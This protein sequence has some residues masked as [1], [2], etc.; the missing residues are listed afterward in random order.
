MLGDHIGLARLLLPEETLLRERL[1]APPIA[2]HGRR[3]ACRER[4]AL[5]L[6][7]E[8]VL[9][10]R[11]QLDLDTAFA[12]PHV[13]AIERKTGR[14]HPDDRRRRFHAERDARLAHEFIGGGIDLETHL[15]GA[16]RR[17]IAQ[18]IARWPGRL[19]GEGE[20]RGEEER[21]RY[22]PIM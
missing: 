7:A 5:H 20:R 21:R 22:F 15:V 18:P 1:D 4:L 11:D 8:I 17:R 19:V 12:L 10:G 16:R 14:V 6:Q 9:A 3:L 2:E 13:D